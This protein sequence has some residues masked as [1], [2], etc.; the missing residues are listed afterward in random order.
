[1]PDLQ[2]T[3][4]TDVSAVPDVTVAESQAPAGAAGSPLP[5][6]GTNRVNEWAAWDP[7]L[8]WTDW[9]LPPDPRPSWER[10]FDWVNQL[11]ALTPALD[12]ASRDW[13]TMIGQLNDSLRTVR[14]MRADLA[15]WTGPSAGTM[16]ESL[17]RMENALSTKIDA[18][19][20]NPARLESLGRTINDAVGPMAA[21]DAEYQQVLADLVA[22]RQVA[23]RGLP[24][25]LN[26]AT[27]LLRTGTELENSVQTDV[28]A[29]QPV[30]PQPL[31]LSGGPQGPGQQPTQVAPV[32]PVAPVVPAPTLAGTSIGPVT[33]TAPAPAVPTAPVPTPTP[34]APAVPAMPATP[35]AAPPVLAMAG[36]APP[37]TPAEP[38][39]AVAATPPALPAAPG[40]TGEAAVPAGLRGRIP[41]PPALER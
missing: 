18:I 26:L 30:P 24:I 16:S 3:T 41:P 17:D 14:G 36:L 23:Q 6:V 7:N 5:T 34:P 2:Q 8:W 9:S 19:G 4:S 13:R 38:R 35:V 32:A 20:Q 28:L 27:E 39:A 21:L 12:E 1:M 11:E 10:W 22:C 25:M 33:A 37:V 15:G 31:T 29:P 40:A